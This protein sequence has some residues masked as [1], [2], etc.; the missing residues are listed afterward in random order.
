[1]PKKRK[2]SVSRLR[3]S[4]DEERAYGTVSRPRKSSDAEAEFRKLIGVIPDYL[5]DFYQVRK[6]TY[7][8]KLLRELIEQEL[9]VDY[10]LYLLG[11]G[12]GEY[13]R[14]TQS[15]DSNFKAKHASHMGQLLESYLSRQVPEIELIGVVRDLRKLLHAEKIDGP[16]AEYPGR[17]AGVSAVEFTRTHYADAIRS[18]S[19]GPGQLQLIDKKLANALRHELASEEPARSVSD[20]F[21]EVYGWRKERTSPLQLKL[22][23]C[24]RLLGV[25]EI[26]AA[27][28]LSGI[29]PD[30]VRAIKPSDTR[31]K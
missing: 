8:I 22:Q 21:N 7:R 23:L 20:F 27:E 9:P 19:L 12:F 10:Y 30:R 14:R 16:L 31:Q 28:F 25:T 13:L 24:A 17:K 3:A 18:G 11:S 29:R 4:I 1:M 5:I 6:Y 15:L 2:P 26:E